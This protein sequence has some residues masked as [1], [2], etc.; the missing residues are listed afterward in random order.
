[1]DLKQ[2]WN[3]YL[4]AE[5]L[6]EQ[7]HWPEAQYLY[8]LVLSNM[9]THIQESANNSATK[10][11]QFV[12]LVSGYRDAAVSQSQILN[13]MGQYQAAF[14]CLNHAHA[15]L[16]FLSIEQNDL[17]RATEH[18]ITKASD[19]LLRHIGAFCS[20]QRNASW[21]FEFEL[22]QK[23]QHYFDTLKCSQQTLT[24]THVMN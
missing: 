10:P 8:D 7:G 1:M 2:C 23:A 17:V 19:D 21:M 18:L 24:R 14:D 12:C 5:Q 6:L 20:S 13:K 9:P 3:H 11:C 22:L 4:K 16:Q 15:L